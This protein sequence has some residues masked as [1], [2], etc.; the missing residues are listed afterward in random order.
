MMVTG[1]SLQKVGRA[2]L[3][4]YIKIA[5]NRR[6]AQRWSEAVIHTDLTAMGTLLSEIKTLAGVNNYATNGI[7]YFIF[8]PR[9]NSELYD[10]NG[11]TIPPG[12]VQFTFS[13]RA[14]RAIAAAVIPL[15]RRLAFDRTYAIRL[16][17]AIR[18][19]DAAAVRKAVRSVVVSPLL[20]S[21]TIE[22]GGIALLFRTPYSKYPYRNLIFQDTN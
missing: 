12:T 17:A 18:N 6:Y 3:P 5:A 9:K 22:E 15:Y 14:H 1:A 16:A 7:G 4:F 10:V 21:V 8:L 11:T 2:M 20:K 13:T 19:N